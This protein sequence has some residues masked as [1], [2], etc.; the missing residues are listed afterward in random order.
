MSR[1]F[2]GSLAM[3]RGRLEQN[4]ADI[5]L[6]VVVPDLVRGGAFFQPHCHLTI[7]VCQMTAL[8]DEVERA[9]AAPRFESCAF[10]RI[11]PMLSA[12]HR[13]EF[14]DQLARG[15]QFLLRRCI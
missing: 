13:V 8:Y 14:A 15:H 9:L 5:E 6:I 10:C 4:P 2:F 1:D 7:E 11:E 12:K 3:S